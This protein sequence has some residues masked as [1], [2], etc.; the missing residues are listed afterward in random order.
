MSNLKW[1]IID[2]NPLGGTIPNLGGMTSL[3]HL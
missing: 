1:L 2:T 3:T